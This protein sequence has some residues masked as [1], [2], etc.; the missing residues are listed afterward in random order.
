MV[1]QHDVN[2]EALRDESGTLATHDPYGNPYPPGYKPLRV[3]RDI[4]KKAL[5][6]NKQRLIAQGETIDEDEPQHYIRI[7]DIVRLKYENDC[8]VAMKK[9]T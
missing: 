4:L 2:K 6:D 7:D 9:I 8:L 1:I 3:D 5:E